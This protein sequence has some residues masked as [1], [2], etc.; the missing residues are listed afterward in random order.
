MRH[1]P[2][3]HLPFNPIIQ[4]SRIVVLPIN[5]QFTYSFIIGIPMLF[6]LFE[7][8][9]FWVTLESDLSDVFVIAILLDDF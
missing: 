3:V 2:F 7:I 8:W 5:M 4:K 9:T 6:E 1:V